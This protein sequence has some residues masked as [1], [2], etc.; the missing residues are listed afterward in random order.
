MNICACFLNFFQSS[1]E[2]VQTLPAKAFRAEI[3]KGCLS[4]SGRASQH[5]P[6]QQTS[7]IITPERE[8]PVRRRLCL[9]GSDDYRFAHKKNKM[10]K[11]AA[12]IRLR[13]EYIFSCLFLG[14]SLGTGRFPSSRRGDN[15]C[16]FIFYLLIVQTNQLK[17]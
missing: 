11:R 13:Q 6:E 3:R 7:I 10:R 5:F 9:R 12:I 17:L 2:T 15:H 14:F 8:C 4:T 1:V 16:R